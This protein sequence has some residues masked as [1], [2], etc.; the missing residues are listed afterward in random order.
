[1]SLILLGST[2]SIGVQSL[3][4]AR[5]EGIEVMGLAAAG[6]RIDLLAE[7]IIEFHPDAVA[8][9]TAEAATNLRAAL[10]TA[11]SGLEIL[12]GPDAATELAARGNDACQ[13]LNGMT[14]AIGLRPTLAALD[15]GARLALANK[16]SLVVGADLV[17]RHMRRDGQ[18]L[19]VDSEHSAIF[20]ALES[21]H[22]GRG[23]TCS[24]RDG[25]SE[26]ERIIVTASGGP[27]RGRTRAELAEVTP[28]Q[29]LKHP[30]WEMG[31]VITINSSTLMNKALE[32]I[33][34]H[35]LYD[36]ETVD[37]TVHPQSM[38]HSLVEF[39]DGSTIAQVSPPDMRLP[40]ALALTWPRRSY[41]APHVDWTQSHTWTFEPVDSETFP[42]I[43]LARA[44]YAASAT[45][46]AVMN[47]ANEECVDAFLSGR[48]GYL[49]IV[50]TV[51]AVV[52]EHEGIPRGQVTLEALDDVQAWA[53]ARAHELMGR[54]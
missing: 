19:P 53:R 36:V 4:V 42:A 26:V 41:P 32:V 33:E 31:P 2:G 24:T 49:G 46:T 8:V 29:A 14:G 35:V 3:D 22:H 48:L 40:I 27:F 6:S 5:H 11:A 21:G 25:A 9:A 10:G 15:S 47:A 34:A 52:E 16:E 30:N 17:T 44:A 20:Q 13:V 50:D 43:E 7:Q 28:A 51:A 39:V 54:A 38:I 1:M 23:L 37:V 18:I 45:H 12:A